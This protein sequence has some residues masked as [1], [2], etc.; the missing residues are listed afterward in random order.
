[1]Y[2]SRECLCIFLCVFCVENIWRAL[3]ISENREP[4]ENLITSTKYLTKNKRALYFFYYCIFATK[5]SVLLLF[6]ALFYVYARVYVFAMHVYCVMCFLA[7]LFNAIVRCVIRARAH[8]PL[9]ICIAAVSIVASTSIAA[10]LCLLIDFVFGFNLLMRRT[11][12]Y[13]FAFVFVVTFFHISIWE[14][15]MFS[16]SI[17]AVAGVCFFFLHANFAPLQYGLCK[18]SAEWKKHIAHISMKI[19]THRNV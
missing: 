5:H 13:C 2:I 15:V 18:S 3:N 14:I 8:V 9:V 6:S 7:W 1:M 17:F 12:L 16:G 11:I 4:T 10:F 19:N